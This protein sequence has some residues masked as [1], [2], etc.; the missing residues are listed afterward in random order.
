MNTSCVAVL[1]AEKFR[2][3]AKVIKHLTNPDVFSNTNVVKYLSR[4]LQAISLAENESLH[5]TIDLPCGLKRTAGEVLAMFELHQFVDWDKAARQS[6][7]H[8]ITL[9]LCFEGRETQGA[10]H[11]QPVKLRASGRIRPQGITGCW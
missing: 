3:A 5:A 10:S 2:L 7:D 9:R 11:V 4:C 1:D 6:L 8:N